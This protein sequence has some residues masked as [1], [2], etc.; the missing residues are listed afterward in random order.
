MAEEFGMII[1]YGA[2]V[3]PT[4]DKNYLPLTL[5]Y[6]ELYALTYGLDDILSELSKNTNK[7]FVKSGTGKS[8][9]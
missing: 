6:L 4:L 8:F 7:E 1:N 3:S 2:F 9:R 5:K